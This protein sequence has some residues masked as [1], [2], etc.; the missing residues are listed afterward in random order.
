MAN[1]V[2][3]SM[4]HDYVV[5]VYSSDPIA[6]LNHQAYGSHAIVDDQFDH[7]MDDDQFIGHDG[8][9]APIWEMTNAF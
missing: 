1:H 8:R 3:Q 7:F 6:Q 5:T 9:L 2:A 4:P